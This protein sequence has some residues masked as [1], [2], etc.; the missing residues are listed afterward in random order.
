MRAL[1]ILA[2]SVAAVGGATAV[3]LTARATVHSAASDHGRAGADS[4][5]VATLLAALAHTDPLIC[6]LIG[7]QLGNFW[8]GGEPGR[9]GRF[10][11]APNV[12]GAKDSL[13]GSIT[14]PRAV[15]LLVGTL[16]TDNQCVRRVAAKLLGQS[17]VSVG[18]LGTLLDNASPRIRESAAYAAGVGERRETRGALERR[19]VDTA[20]GPA[21]MAAWALGEI[22]DP[23]SA[24]ALQAAVHAQSPRV[25]LASAWALGQFEDATYAKDVLPLLRDADP[26]MRA[27]AAEALGKMKSPRVGAALVGALTDR[28]DAV[29]RAAVH[30]LADMHE[31][32]AVAPIE[33]LLL[34]DPDPDVRRE[35]ASALGNISLG[36]SL[37]PLARALSDQDVEVQRAAANAI[38][39]LEDVTKAPAALIRATTSTDLELRRHATRA[40]AHIGDVATVQV[41]VDRLGDDDKDVRL[42]AVEGLGEMKVAAAIPGLTRALNDRD[43]EVRRA[44]AEALGKTQD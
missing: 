39:D 44:A 16:G 36:R 31:Q 34:N 24:P 7:D 28:N 41:L 42:A 37:E 20:T 11:D 27:T 2:L 4:A 19:L 23:A 32:S 5:R 9:L 17:T 14:D 33:G 30:A 21:A 18:V 10:D 1:N 8:M 22:E 38:G 12:Q 13:A 43:P 29:R 40:L 35:C 26:V 25:R 3:G 6:D 15:S